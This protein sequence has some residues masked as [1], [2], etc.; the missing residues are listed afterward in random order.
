MIEQALAALSDVGAEVV[1]EPVVIQ[2]LVVDQ[3]QDVPR[4]M[5]L[6]AL[7]VVFVGRTEAGSANSMLMT[8]TIAC[9][10]SGR[11]LRPSA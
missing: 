7:S 3:L 6:P 9:A 2:E 1:N 8:S 10:L 11:P 4:P 5:A